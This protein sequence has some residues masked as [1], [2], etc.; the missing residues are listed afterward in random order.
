MFDKLD[1]N[2]NG[3][4]TREEFMAFD[5]GAKRGGK[6][7]GMMKMADANN[8]GRITQAEMTSAVL[9]HFD[10]A[11]TNKDG[12]VSADEHKAMRQQM[13]GMNHGGMNHGDMKHGND[14]S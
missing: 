5:H 4:I 13:R 7:G 8:D 10:M 11:D 2:K 12:Q 3:Q 14:A 9:A 1:T 6:D